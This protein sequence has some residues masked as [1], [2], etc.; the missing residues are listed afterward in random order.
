MSVKVLILLT[1]PILAISCQQQ[2]ETEEPAAAPLPDAAAGPDIPQDKGYLVE[3]IQ[4]CLY[5]VTEG[6]YHSIFISTWV[7][8][9]VVD[10][11]QSLGVMLG[12]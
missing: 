10:V 2:A 8:V 11:T 7:G 12:K 1:L 4:D 3:E 5:W 9:I 6:V